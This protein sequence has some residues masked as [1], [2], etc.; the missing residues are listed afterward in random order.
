MVAG[1]GIPFA[2]LPA[3]VDEAP[4]PGEAPGPYLVRVVDAKLA[5]VRAAAPWDARTVL[6]A[7]TAVVANGTTILGKPRDDADARSMLDLLSGEVHEVSTRFC[8]APTSASAPPWRAETVTTKVAFRSLGRDE[9]DVYVATGEG[10]DKAG[11]YAIQGAAAG[12]VR[13]IEGS[14]TNVVG[15]PLCEVIEAL[16]A[17]RLLGP[18]V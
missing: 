17:A 2:V 13:R 6:V 5:A 15:L 8:L 11:A 3:E 4:R 16:R 9:I 14:Y 12:F 7:D 1:L 18:A 10:R